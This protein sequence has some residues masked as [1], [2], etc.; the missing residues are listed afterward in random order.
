MATVFTT[1]GKARLVDIAQ[2][3]IS[4]ETLGKYLAWGTG[5]GT[6]D[7]GDTTL[8]TEASETRVAGAESQPAADKYRVVGT[9]T[10]DGTKTITNAG[11]FSAT[12]S[13]GT[14]VV[15]GDFTGVA[16]NLGDSITFTV[17]LQ[18]T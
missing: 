14:L 15:K 12:P 8:F 18:I 10:A 11:T 2:Q 5:V 16:V 1:V 17:D 6:A 4:G 9:I 3:T 13:G 7:V